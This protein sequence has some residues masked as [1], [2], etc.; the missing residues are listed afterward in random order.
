MIEI[1]SVIW[2]W[3]KPLLLACIFA[4]VASV[5][6]SLFMKNY[7]ESTSTMFATNPYRMD[8]QYLFSKEPG[9]NPVYDLGGSGEIDRFISV[10]N[11]RPLQDFIIEKFD[12]MNH[13][14]IDQEDPLKEFKVRKE[15]MSNFNVMKNALEAIEITVRDENP[16]K[17]A[18]MVNAI[19][20][21]TD[22][23]NLEINN[24]VSSNI[25]NVFSELKVEKEMEFAILSD[26]LDILKRK[27]L[28]SKAELLEGILATKTEELSEISDLYDQYKSTG[29]RTYSTVYILDKA[30]PALK[31]AGPKRTLIVLGTILATLFL[32][33]L[34]VLFIEQ[35]KKSDF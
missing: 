26:S 17:A 33:T 11:S 16:E 8:R 27:R 6:V 21:K 3:K 34:T 15:F 25:M 32:S 29:K 13:Y 5:I 20:D 24:M 35:L 31:K 12:L 18:D 10:C 1:L 4:A 7:F 28:S 14:D 2:R 23:L 22:E 9:K 30:R 19:V